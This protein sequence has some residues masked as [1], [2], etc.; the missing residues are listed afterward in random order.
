MM[1]LVL[2][3]NKS[4][5]MKYLILLSLILLSFA[6]DN[7]RY[8]SIYRSKLNLE[9]SNLQQQEMHWFSQVIDHYDYQK[10]QYFKHR[11]WVIKDYFNP[12]AGPVFLYICGE[13][14]CTGVP[15]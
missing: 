15:Q 10:E 12:K 5:R 14:E 11:Y 13:W 6:R 7:P 4:I 9:N 1:I 8:D 3:N 2:I